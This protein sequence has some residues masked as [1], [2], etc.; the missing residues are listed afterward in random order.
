MSVSTTQQLMQSVLDRLPA[1]VSV[2]KVF[3]EPIVSGDKTII[4]VA[5]IAVGFGGG[6]G[7]GQSRPGRSRPDKAMAESI[8]ER[9]GDGGGMGGG[10]MVHPLG[11]IEVTPMHTHYIPLR[12]GRFVA[13][14]VVLGL[15][16]GG[17]LRRRR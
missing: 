7:Q 16:L 3:G 15:V 12:P 4:P 17:V 14:G 2:R 8:D 1:D 9:T 6:Y 13:L 10:L 11:V 5:R